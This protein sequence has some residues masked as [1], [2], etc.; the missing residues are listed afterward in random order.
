MI[1]K[2]FN[3]TRS[4]I[5]AFEKKGYRGT[6]G[7]LRCEALLGNSGSYAFQVNDNTNKLV[8]EIRLRQGD[9]FIPTKIGF[10]V[11]KANS[12]TLTDAL[13][14]TSVLYTFP[15]SQVFTGT[16]EASNLQALWNSRLLI[17]VNSVNLLEYM[18]T[19]RFRRVSLAQKGLAVSTVATTGVVQDNEWN[20][21][22]YGF[23]PL[24][25][26]LCFN[27]Q[28]NNTLGLALPT[29]VDCTGTTSSNYA[30]VMFKGVLVPNGA[31]AIKDK[32]IKTFVE[33]SN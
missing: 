22:D 9:A 28:A 7:T 4:L 6:E 8:T 25:Q 31:A 12:A 21:S 29:S 15:N 3:R 2:A 19:L 1:P 23:C 5:N 18:D 14:A 10:F 20:S 24:E 33:G 11:R 26:D 30:V 13:Q 27:G 17:T 32:S 16:N